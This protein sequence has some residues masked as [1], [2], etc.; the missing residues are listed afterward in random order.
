MDILQIAGVPSFSASTNHD[1]IATNV[2][3]PPIR[4]WQRPLGTDRVNAIALLFNDTGELMPNPVLLGENV[5]GVHP[6]I[7]IVPVQAPGGGPTGIFEVQFVPRT[8]QE[9]PALWILDGQHRINGLANSLQKLNE[10]PVVF[11]L[12]ANGNFYSGPLLAKLFAQVTTSAQKLDDLHN[13]WLTFAFNLGKY[14]NVNTQGSRHKKSMESVAE[15]C[16]RPLLGGITNPFFNQVKFNIHK[17]ATPAPGGFSYTCEELEALLFNYYFSR[18]ATAGH[19]SPSVVAE[20]LVLAHSA[21]QANV[22]NPGNSV[23]FGTGNY[24]QGIMQDAFIAGVLGYLGTNGIPPDWSS[25][26]QM[27][28]FHTTNW[29]FNWVG[30]LNG[31]DQTVSKNLATTLFIESFVK[32][33]LPVV[34]STSIADILRGNNAEIELEF[35]LLTGTGRPKKQGRTT[36]K[37]QTGNIKTQ[38]IAPAGH[39]KLV[40]RSINVGALTITDKNSPPGRVVEYKEIAGRGLLLTAAL[41][42]KPL[43]LLIQMRHYGGNVSSASLDIDW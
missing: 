19:L 15:I 20:Q 31:T 24:G 43:M 37:L 13:E 26:L 6:A 10:V 34:G 14:S 21:L 30:S 38:Q 27:L 23:F 11:L 41:H 32:K 7:T 22:S 9:E 2:L 40:A 16:K 25:L 33:A 3:T 35:S 1:V 5:A 12:N 8:D 28:A 18:P 42:A 29:H 39:V 17:T 4:E 36:L